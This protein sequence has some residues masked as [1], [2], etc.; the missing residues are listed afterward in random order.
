MRWL[1]FC[2]VTGLV[3][4]G[5]SP[6]VLAHGFRLEQ[7]R[8]EAIVI[9][10]LEDSGKPMIGAMV[11]VYTP[12]DRSTPWKTGATDNQGQFIFIPDRT[13]PGVWTVQ[14]R[15]AGH[16]HEIAV[17]VLPAPAPQGNPVIASSPEALKPD[18]LPSLAPSPSPVPIESNLSRIPP[19]LP[20][21][22]AQQG[23]LVGSVLWGF[24]GTILFFSRQPRKN[25]TQ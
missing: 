25:V 5:F 22:P 17:E 19:V 13:Q 23:L 15:Q 1:P 12:S 7:Q 24:V 9:Q 21:S 10:S 18:I 8:T 16:G 3:F 2:V 11:L 6:I 20:N 14:V 4:L